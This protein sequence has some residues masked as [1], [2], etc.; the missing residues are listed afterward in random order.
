MK[1]ILYFVPDLMFGTKIE[2]A[3]RKLGYNAVGV[4]ADSD[5]DS[6]IARESPVLILLTFDRTGQVW[7]TLAESAR[8][9]SIK[10]VAFGSHMNLNAF[11]RA[12]ELG[13]KEVVANS[14]LNAELP[15]LLE[16][17]VS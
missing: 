17:W 1:T 9:A 3:T 7:E 13:C 14:R 8:R 4:S 16:K 6:L 10:C 15:Q 2:D 12:K 11:A 5:F